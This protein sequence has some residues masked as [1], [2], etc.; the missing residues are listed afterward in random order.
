MLAPRSSPN[1]LSEGNRALATETHV[2][3]EV[4]NHLLSW[5]LL[6]RKKLHRDENILAGEAP[7]SIYTML[8]GENEEKTIVLLSSGDRVG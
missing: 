4:M 6:K 3:K 8:C 2:H 1:A 7:K 5:V